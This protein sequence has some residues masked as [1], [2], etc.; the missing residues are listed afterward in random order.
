M[1]ECN[2][3]YLLNDPLWNIITL[4][5]VVLTY[6]LCVGVGDTNIQS[7]PFGGLAATISTFLEPREAK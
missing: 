7:Q 4:G 5:I 3:N 2:P 6:E 1:T